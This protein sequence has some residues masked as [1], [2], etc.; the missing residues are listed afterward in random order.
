MK[1]ALILTL[2]LIIIP[3]SSAISID[4]NKT[5]APQ[6]TLITEISGIILSPIQK[7]D[8]EL[9]R[10]NVQVP[11]EYDIRRINN[12]YHFYAVLP[13]NPNN[14]TLIINDVTTTI[15]GSTQTIDFEKTIEVTGEKAPYYV[16]PGF[17]VTDKNFEITIISTEDFNQQ[18]PLSSGETITLSPG[19][20][21]IT[22]DIEKF[23]EGL[24][25]LGIG[26]YEIP[27]FSTKSSNGGNIII[28]SSSRVRFYPVEIESVVLV[29]STPS[30]PV[31][32]TNL[33]EY[34]IPF[35]LIYDDSIF[36]ITPDINTIPPGESLEF[37]LEIL[38]QTDINDRIFLA[39]EGGQTELPVYISY[40]EEESEVETPYLEEEP[41]N[42]ELF[43]CSE[44][45]GTFC[46]AN[47]IC[48]G[49]LTS[50]LDGLSCCIG[51]CT[52]DTE[53]GRS[54]AWLGYLIGII[55]IILLVFIIIKYKKTGKIF[56]KK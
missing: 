8:I 7:S 53:S 22:F 48:S 21:K 16:K 47:E 46:S 32:I 34:E 35:S 15:N 56:S 36:K 9:K 45:G 19:E 44:L 52:A 49:D 38:S 30:Y 29:G 3:L 2:F 28:P 13:E 17:V 20:N 50:T 26:F 18:I 51:Q 23:P 31:R 4:I 5:L 14:Y 11:F 43:Y 6:E 37:N 10:I 41:S 25:Y 42:T 27:V 33:E 24:S 40:T 12:I 39:Y 1:R 54:L 55:L